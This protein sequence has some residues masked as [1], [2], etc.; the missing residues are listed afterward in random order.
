MPMRR[1]HQH[2]EP[3]G[4]E[5]PVT[6][7]YRT[8]NKSTSDEVEP[9]KKVGTL[10]FLSPETGLVLDL[11]DRGA[12]TAAV[13]SEPQ[14]GI[15]YK[16]SSGLWSQ[17]SVTCSPLNACLYVSR[18]THAPAILTVVPLPRSTANESVRK[19]VPTCEMPLSMGI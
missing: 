18:L 19:P 5:Q 9:L 3:E 8:L 13:T 12:A 15:T 11:G 1:A 7:R 16:S 4:A 6:K 17:L 14:G 10:Y 2:A